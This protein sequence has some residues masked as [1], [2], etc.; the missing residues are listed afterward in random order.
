MLCF[1]LAL[2]QPEAYVSQDQTPRE[3]SN[4]SIN[5]SQ[6]RAQRSVMFTACRLTAKTVRLPFPALSGRNWY[7]FL[8]PAERLE[9]RFQH[10]KRVPC[11]EQTAVKIGIAFLDTFPRIVIR[12]G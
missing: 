4:R 12:A 6:G 7:V 1:K 10:V 8:I 2:H 9:L 11:D 3:R 5:L